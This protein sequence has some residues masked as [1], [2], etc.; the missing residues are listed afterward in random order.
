MTDDDIIND[1][2]I[3]SMVETWDAEPWPTD[4]A[5]D[6]VFV[7]WCDLTPGDP[8]WDD[9]SLA[10]LVRPDRS[11]EW[12]DGP[13]GDSPALTAIA[14]RVADGGESGR[15]QA[16]DGLLVVWWCRST[17]DGPAGDRATD[18]L[19]DTGGES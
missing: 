5:G 1:A 6:R 8:G 18:W 10:G 9:W 14:A 7:R 13:A 17:L 12:L 2:V 4:A 16:S 11:V 3:R 15:W 19:T